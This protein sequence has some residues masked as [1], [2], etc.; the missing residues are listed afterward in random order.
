M[1]LRILLFC[2]LI[3]Q[4]AVAQS[5]GFPTSWVGTWQGDLEIYN[6]QGQVQTLAMK[7]EILP[8]DTSENFTWTIIY[9]S[10]K[11]AQKRPY[12]LV[13]INAATG[14]YLIDEKNSIR[15][16][17]YLLGSKLFQRFS[18]MGNMLTATNTVQ[19]D[20]MIF[21]IFSGKD[22]PSTTSG[23]TKFEGEAIPEVQAFPIGTY[24][25]A[26]LLRQ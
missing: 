12:E 11:E 5:D 16:D 9:G 10:G 22:Q 15:I 25:R 7:L 2:S 1:A 19:E 26:V 8:I 24:Q 6:A 23:G 14:H 13:T 20:T 21:E 17:A 4:T 3:T 18:V